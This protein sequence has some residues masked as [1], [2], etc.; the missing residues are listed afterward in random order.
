MN[1]L[2][3]VHS[4]A[5][6]ANIYLYQTWAPADTAFVLSGSDLASGAQPG[7]DVC[8]FGRTEQAAVSRGISPEIAVRLQVVAGKPSPGETI[9]FSIQMRTSARLLVSPG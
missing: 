7:A 9:T 1:P 8:H 4:A 5:P 2:Q 6:D 3:G